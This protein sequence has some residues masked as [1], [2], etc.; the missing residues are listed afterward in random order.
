M[1][2][3]IGL[4]G[5][6]TEPMLGAGAELGEGGAVLG[7]AVADV[8]FKTIAGILHSEADHI[9]VAGDFGNNRGGGNVFHEVVGAF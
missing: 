5:A 7:G 9:L 2:L 8:F 6:E 3:G 1:A 4:E